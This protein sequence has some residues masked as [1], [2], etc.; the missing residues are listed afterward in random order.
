MKHTLQL[1]LLLAS[2]YLSSA[3]VYNWAY[4]AGG[5]GWD[6]LRSIYLS[7][8]NGVLQT[9]MFSGT[10]SFGATTLNSAGFQ[11]AFVAKYDA[12]GNVLWAKAISGTEQDWGYKVCA[13]NQNNVYV[14]GYFQSSAL[15]FTPSDSI[16]R[17]PASARNLFLAKYSSNGTF[18][19]VK[20][21]SAGATNG[22]LTARSVT[23]DNQNNI[24]LSGD[25]TKEIQFDATTLPFTNA[26]NIFLVKFDTNG[27][28]LWHK[29]GISNSI[30]WFNDMITDATN[31]IYV[32]GKISTT[33]S[34]GLTSIP[35]HGGDDLVVGKFDPN[36]NLLWM[37]VEGK[38]IPATTTS[39]N[40]D[41][42]NS[43]ALDPSGNIY[44][45]GS[46]LDTTYYHA[47]TNSMITK[48]WAVVAKFTNNGNLLWLKK[49]GNHEKN[50]IH[51]ITVDNNGDL[52]AIG[53]YQDTLQ[54]GG[55]NLPIASNPAAFV[56][57]FAANNGNTLFAYQNGSSL[58]EWEGIGIAINPLSGHL[59]TSGNYRSQVNFG[60]NT[61]TSNGVWDIY[62]TLLNNAIVQGLS[63][64]TRNQLITLYPNPGSQYLHFDTH[65]QPIT[66]L[67]ATLYSTTGQTLAS[68]PLTQQLRIPISSLASGNYILELSDQH[69]N[70]Y[71]KLFTKE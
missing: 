43:I 2:S 1:I 9:G 45:G 6:D 52:Y 69:H 39:Y 31:N 3:Q 12:M 21:G 18:L 63:D 10:A 11:D 48:Q 51:D 38:P 50:N 20:H 14:T 13:D 17:S 59:I 33:I 40:F 57:K 44:I 32:C 60:N 4:S 35:N 70:S 55:T 56:A 58:T 62:I 49:F 24:I 37:H 64:P 53:V 29:A 42:S 30:C 25:Y 28:L 34:F 54:V 67:H 41:C 36:G 65:N 16:V 46:L 19:W 71:W 68:Y 23:V 66:L 27:N 7:P 22:M 15:Y 5:T 8:D 47:P 26:A 61:L